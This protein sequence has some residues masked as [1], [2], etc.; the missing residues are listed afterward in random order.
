M[1]DEQQTRVCS[2]LYQHTT[3]TDSKQPADGYA[4]DNL[5][6]PEEEPAP[7]KRKQSKAAEA[8]AK[9]KEKAKAKAKAKKGKGKKGDDDEDYEDSDQDAYS[10]LSKMWKGD[11]PK[12]PVGASKTARGA[13]SNSPW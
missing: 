1:T 4:S 10:A 13:R 11:L 9:E 6:E 8:K 12:P 2:S 5:D 3:R 7:K